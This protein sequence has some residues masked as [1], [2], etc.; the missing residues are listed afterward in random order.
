[1]EHEK[2]KRTDIEHL[3]FS[4]MNSNLN[5][6]FTLKAV[7]SD[8]KFYIQGT[9]F[10]IALGKYVKVDIKH[11]EKRLNT[12][13]RGVSKTSTFK[14]IEFALDYSYGTFDVVIKEMPALTNK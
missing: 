13:F 11:L 7:S 10:D 9:E 2:L 6:N 3:I 12:I 14:I 5:L 1:M 4:N 8:K